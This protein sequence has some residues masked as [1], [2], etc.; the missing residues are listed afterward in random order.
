MN[1]RHLPLLACPACSSPLRC[2]RTV[3]GAE[4]TLTEGALGCTRCGA[5]YPVVGGI[6]RFVPR[7][8]YASGF[9]LEWTRHARTQYDSHCGL[10]VS[11][12]RFFAQTHWPTQ[13]TGELVLEVGSGS[14][15]FTEQVANTGATVVSFDYSYA[16]EA[17]FASNGSR[18]NVLIVQADVFAMPFPAGR[19]DRLFC[20]GMLQHTPDPAR[21]F[22]ALPRML[23][24]G[25][26]L[27]AD[28]YKATLFRAFCHTKYYIRP[29]T[30]RMDP[31][32]LYRRVV[33][34]VDFMWPAAALI[35]RL[36]KGSSIN[37][38][39]LVADYSFLGLQGEILKEWSYLDTFDMLA[40]RYDRPARIGTVRRWAREAGLQAA[41]AEYTAHGIVLRATAAGAASAP[42]EAAPPGPT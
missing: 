41:Q 17:N 38:R 21:A 9:G 4:R 5:E 10:P 20:F 18:E 42:A 6:P 22:A 15:R 30:R 26:A 31:D 36:P 33:A 40:P 19:F 24:P 27:C 23:R 2:A 12:Q 39:L 11:Q 16:V 32:R 14:G 13:L 37:W 28:I 29:F 7:E 3:Q 8:N 25:G 34:W 1:L 35:R